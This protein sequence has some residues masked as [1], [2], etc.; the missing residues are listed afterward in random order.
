MLNPADPQ[1]FSVAA[2]DTEIRG[3]PVVRQIMRTISRTVGETGDDLYREARYLL[4][5][6][7]PGS[8]VH[9]GL[10]RMVKAGEELGAMLD[11]HEST[12]PEVC[13]S[14]LALL[15][16]P[17]DE[18]SPAWPRLMELCETMPRELGETPREHLR[19]FIDRLNP[20]L[21][22]DALSPP[23]GVTVTTVHE[24]KGLEWRVAVV[25]DANVPGEERPQEEEQRIRFTAI[26][27]AS[28]VVLYIA[29]MHTSNGL[30]PRNWKVADVLKRIQRDLERES[31]EAVDE[32]DGGPTGAA[33]PPK[34]D[35]KSPG[36]GAGAQPESRP[37]N[38]GTVQCA[39]DR[40]PGQVG[41]TVTLPSSDHSRYIDP[42]FEFL[43]LQRV[44]PPDVLK[45]NV[46]K[47]AKLLGVSGLESKSTK[48]RIPLGCIVSVALLISAAAAI[49]WGIHRLFS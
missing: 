34:S 14:A 41:P 30:D 31:S 17:S 49:T 22:P 35:G 9:D 6:F 18:V 7:R 38:A 10:G 36:A 32:S 16:V 23:G 44:Y 3:S 29:L 19:R 1:V 5:S 13:R 11:N 24:A 43:V 33:R 37:N 46:I 28:D 45:T 42:E 25:L 12:L 48:Q 21:Y 27:R 26:T 2:F 39:P 8:P 47:A 4:G 15:Q 40:A 20:G